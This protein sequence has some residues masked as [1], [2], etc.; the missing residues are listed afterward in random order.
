MKRVKRKD[1]VSTC[2]T[3]EQIKKS[4]RSWRYEK[5][6]RLQY[7]HWNFKWTVLRA[8][9]PKT[10]KTNVQLANAEVLT[11]G[12]AEYSQNQNEVDDHSLEPQPMFIYKSLHIEKVKLDP[13]PS[14][15]VRGPLPP[16]IDN[17]YGT[18]ISTGGNAQ[19]MCL[20]WGQPDSQF[21]D[22]VD[23][24]SK[25]PARSGNRKCKCSC[26][27]IFSVVLVLRCYCPKLSHSVIWSRIWEEHMVLNP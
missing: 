16:N 14:A 8:Q 10:E 1:H 20:Y 17:A 6:R 22:A 25:C 15:R 13:I 19:M 5:K 3:T 4:Q 2:R 11:S 24:V 21:G 12:T 9:Q 23:Q 7:W 26:A 18:R 27:Q